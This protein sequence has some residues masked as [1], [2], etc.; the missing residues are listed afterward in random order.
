MKLHY[1]T[2]VNQRFKSAS[3]GR[4]LRQDTGQG[5]LHKHQETQ[6]ALTWFE[7]DKVCDSKAKALFTVGRLRQIPAGCPYEFWATC[8]ATTA[9]VSDPLHNRYWLTLHPSGSATCMCEDWL[10]NGGACKHLR[11]LRLLLEQQVANGALTVSHPFHFPTTRAEAEEVMQRNKAWYGPHFE[12]LVTS[13]ASVALLAHINT[14]GRPS[15]TPPSI[16]KT[17]TI[18][19]HGTTTPQKAPLA[20]PTLSME[21]GTTLADQVVLQHL[22]GDAIH[23]EDDK[24][25]I[26]DACSEGGECD[27]DSDAIAMATSQVCNN[28]AIAV[29]IQQHVVHDVS[30]VLPTLHGLSSLL[31]DSSLSIIQGSAQLTE[32]QD[33]LE[34]LTTKISRI[35][36]AA[37]TS[38]CQPSASTPT[39]LISRQQHSDL[40]KAGT[41][42]CLTVVQGILV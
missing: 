14:C 31:D 21:G 10:Q 27:V 4:N 3:G 22:A 33:V 23:L 2:W 5:V 13:Y 38:P 28:R 32:F 12:A 18:R 39:T 11:A 29:Q 16:M 30:K 20:P 9:D 25:D 17:I 19:E 36:N 35:G 24:E 6:V 15:T 7:P 1:E 42:S 26:S 41:F 37:V 34:T 40:G 8:A